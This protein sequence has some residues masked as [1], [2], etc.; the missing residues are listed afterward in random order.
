MSPT[1]T[2]SESKSSSGNGEGESAFNDVSKEFDTLQDEQNK[3]PEFDD[4]G[5]LVISDKASEAG[6]K[7][8][9]EHAVRA[10][11]TYN[12][13]GPWPEGLLEQ[14][15]GPRRI[16]RSIGEYTSHES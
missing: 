4:D 12:G 9:E 10:S 1:A 11:A 13:G 15:S 6:Q 5:N 16:S 2:K 3:P 14:V 8:A 7:L